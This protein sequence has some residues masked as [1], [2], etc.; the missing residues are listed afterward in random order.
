MQD[1][2]GLGKDK[3]MSLHESHFVTQVDGT[4]LIKIIQSKSSSAGHLIIYEQV[5]ECY[6]KIDWKKLYK[7]TEKLK[8]KVAKIIETLIHGLGPDYIIIC[9]KVVK[10]CLEYSSH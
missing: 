9:S 1:G 10:M 3:N 6:I 2:V 5:S 8:A 7:K 4:D